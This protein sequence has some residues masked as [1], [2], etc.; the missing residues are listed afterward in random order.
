[1]VSSAPIQAIT[2]SS[3]RSASAKGSAWEWITPPRYK[4]EA[5]ILHHTATTGRSRTCRRRSAVGPGPREGPARSDAR[6]RDDAAAQPVDRRVRGAP[7]LGD[8]C[9]AG[10]LVED[11]DDLLAPAHEVARGDLRAAQHGVE[12]AAHGPAVHGRDQ[13]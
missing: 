9:G 12:V 1:A 4:V 3:T 2:P 13:A 10:D 5:T 7:Q 8:G 6:V 11:V